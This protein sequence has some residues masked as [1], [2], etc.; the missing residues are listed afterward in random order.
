MNKIHKS[1]DLG[2]INVL[3]SIVQLKIPLCPQSKKAEEREEEIEEEGRHKDISVI[4]FFF[5]LKLFLHN[6]KIRNRAKRCSA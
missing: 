1:R 5:P 4:V 3:V 6:S 2:S